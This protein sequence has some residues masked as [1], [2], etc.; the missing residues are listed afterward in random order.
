MLLVPA[1]N[2]MFDAAVRR[3]MGTKMHP[4]MAIYATLGLLLLVSS[5]VAGYHM[6]EG[7][8]RS[9]V[10]SLAFVVAIAVSFYVILDFEFPRVGII[11]IDSFDQVFVDLRK[12]MN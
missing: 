8:A 1:L 3:T 4:P 11:R 9:W 12:S 10:H 6:G 2:D 5:L 7:R